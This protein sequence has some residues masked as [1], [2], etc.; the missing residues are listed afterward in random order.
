[1]KY[2]YI[3]I[4]REYA[5]G[6]SEIGEKLSGKLGIPCY[7]REILR[8][9]AE[10]NG[11]TPEQIQGLEESATNSF[12][13]SIAMMAQLSSGQGSGL[14]QE[15]MLYLAEA[16]TI[17]H[18]VHEGSCILVGRCAS[19]VLRERTD[20]LNVFIHADINMRKERAESLYGIPDTK[21]GNVLKKFDKRR[22]NYYSANTGKRWDDK[23]GYHLVLDSSKLGIEKCVDILAASI[24]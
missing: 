13:Y 18:L 7:G 4:E 2:N 22:S 9:V 6:G 10:E 24:K 11:T 5:S 17:Y 8:R 20:V 12:L 23:S 16:K 1:M 14:S 21:V 15:N 3:A 19:W